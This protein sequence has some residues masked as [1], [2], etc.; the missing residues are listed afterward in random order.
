MK[1]KQW[2][3]EIKNVKFGGSN[4]GWRK[5][6]KVRGEKWNWMIQKSVMCVIG[7]EFQEYKMI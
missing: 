7:K 1:L 4:E 6:W 2:N 5:S 3:S